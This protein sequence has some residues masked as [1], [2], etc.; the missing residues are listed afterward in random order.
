MLVQDWVDTLSLSLRD[1]WLQFTGFLP[2]LIG[3]LVVLIIGIIVASGLER[4]VERLIYYLKI[5]TLM[6]QV[7]VEAFMQR[8]G[9]KLNTGHFLGK[10]VYW[11]FIVVF[12]LASSDILGFGALS[13]FL[14]EVLNYIPSVIIAVLILLA[15][16]V[17]ANFLKGLVK[18][19]VMGA[20]LHAG[21]TLG[22][23]A[24]WG[25]AVF[26]FLTA[27]AQLGVA[28]QI[29]NTLITGLVAML[30]LAGGLAFG[31]G[32]KEHA[33]DWLSKMRDELNHH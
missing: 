15:S 33:S 24:W 18:A 7:G 23:I 13:V 27:L 31:L 5:D 8:A 30:A 17:V 29:I 10:L 12:L 19:S 11:F 32:G 22:T 20:R 28:V 4:L 3:A 9:M 2:E 25:V 14:K 16:L 21:K 26:G 6:K 1:L